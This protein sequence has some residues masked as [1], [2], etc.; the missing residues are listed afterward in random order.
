[1]STPYG[2]PPSPAAPPVPPK[3]SRTGLY[4]A[5]ACG[6]VALLVLVIGG[7]GAGIFF[8][9]K[10]DP[11]DPPTAIGT[12]TED[13]TEDP[14]TDPTVDPIEMPTE[15][16][17]ESPTS[18]AGASF[19]IKVSSPEEGSTLTKQDGETL[20]TENGKFVGVEVVITNTG[21]T[22]I[23]LSTK[24]FR[25]YDEDG[26]SHPLLYGAFSTSGPQIAPGEE[27]RAQLYADVPEDMSLTEI[28]Y[29]DEAGTGGKELTFP[30]G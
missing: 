26:M 21:D 15:D 20:D 10:D 5:L 27:A 24:N 28:S 7:I 8:L 14:T 1:M 30:V 19:T 2:M 18:E 23:G 22:E 13:P 6:C 4:I 16:P 25:F 12:S 9:G 3:K 29:T 11:E 17:D